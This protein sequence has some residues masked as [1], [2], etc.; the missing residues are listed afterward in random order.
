MAVTEAEQQFLDQVSLDLP[1]SLVETFAGMPRWQP[2]D[3]NRAAEVIAGKLRAAGV[4]VEVHRPEIYLS[5]PQ[6]A[7]VTAGGSTF[8]AKAPSSSRSVPDGQEGRL[9]RL[10]A[11]PKALRSYNRDVA[12]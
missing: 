2:E 1:W 3:V 10:D 9:V 6:S 7:S 4:P 11:N 8:R 12:T 5:I